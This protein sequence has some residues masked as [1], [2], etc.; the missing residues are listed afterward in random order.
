MFKKAKNRF[1]TLEDFYDWY[2]SE[3]CFIIDKRPNIKVTTDVTGQRFSQLEVL[4]LIGKHKFQTLWLCVCD[5]G[6]YCYK[7]KTELTNRLNKSC[8]CYQLSLVT[9]HGH[10]TNGKTSHLYNLW[11]GRKERGTTKEKTF[12]EF[13]KNHG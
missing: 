5:C 8:G 13:L 10:T 7:Y 9:T 4:E 1:K 2:E 3:E 11:R 12:K 6:L